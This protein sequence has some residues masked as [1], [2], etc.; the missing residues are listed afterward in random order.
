MEGDTAFDR[1]I[2]GD[3]LERWRHRRRLPSALRL[4]RATSVSRLSA[5][6]IQGLER[7][8]D[9]GWV[10]GVPQRGGETANRP[11]VELV[12]EDIGLTDLPWEIL[13]RDLGF[14]ALRT[15]AV[16]PRVA[17]V[18]LTVPLRMLAVDAPVDA[19][20]VGMGFAALSCGAA[21]VEQFVWDGRWPTVD[22]LH[23]AGFGDDDLLDFAH[24][25]LARTAGWIE[26]I[27]HLHHV[28][29]LVL[30]CPRPQVAN[31]RRLVSELADRGGPAMAVVEVG[32][33]VLPQL[34][35]ALVAPEGF[36]G[37]YGRLVGRGTLI[38][39]QARLELL[40]VNEVVR[41]I[42]HMAEHPRHK[43]DAQLL[44]LHG[45]SLVWRMFEAPDLSYVL[46]RDID[47]FR[48]AMSA[49]PL[50]LMK[51]F[52]GEKV[53]YLVPT[54]AREGQ[55]GVEQISEAGEPLVLD[56][57]IQLQV[58]V[59]PSELRVDVLDAVALVDEIFS[60]DHED[61]GTWVELGVTGIDTDIQG[62]AVQQLWVPR[63]GPSQTV[64]FTVIPRAG[65][66]YVRLAIYVEQ[67]VA[68]TILISMLAR[69]PSM[70]QGTDGR[71][72]MSDQLRRDGRTLPETLPR[73]LARV[74]Y[75]LL[76][77][78]SGLGAIP[79]RAASVVVNHLAGTDVVT[80]KYA[81]GQVDVRT[82]GMAAAGADVRRALE[83]ISTITAAEGARP[84][85]Y[86]FESDE[87][88]DPAL[89][90]EYL[91]PLAA[92]GRGLFDSMIPYDARE[93]VSAVVQREGLPVHVANL[94]MEKA[95]PWAAVYDRPI[96]QHE[97]RYLCTAALPD[98]EGVMPGVA[99]GE[100]PA[101]LLSANGS[102]GELL[103]SEVICPQ[104]FW[105]FRQNV[106]M[107]V[108]RS[109]PGKH[110]ADAARATAKQS[111]T[112]VGLA[113][114]RGLTV[115]G[116]HHDELVKLLGAADPRAQKSW[117][118]EN[119]RSL[120][121]SLNNDPVDLIYF[122]SHAN[123]A[124]GTEGQAGS[125]QVW[126]PN[127][128]GVLTALTRADFEGKSWP[129]RPLV[130]LNGCRTAASDPSAISAL[131]Q[132]LTADR[133]AGGAIGT[134]IA[135]W[136]QLASCVGQLLV[137]RFLASDAAGDALLFARRRL[138]GRHNPLGLAYSLYATTEFYALAQAE[139]V[140][141]AAA[142]AAAA[143]S[144]RLQGPALSL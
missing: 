128:K 124:D 87:P 1:E 72:A 80:V 20:I 37:F 43:F 74:E 69:G 32:D 115:G 11:L 133:G 104:G 111:P 49:L 5:L 3:V 52:H 110:A 79:A 139:A 138:L 47:R 8:Q 10:S 67:N 103:A 81:G 101:C 39:G 86:R 34:L 44:E 127:E 15:S 70:A 33:T 19:A 100:A 66:S 25:Q 71:E 137:E 108:Q 38:G 106:E 21:N 31:A 61:G 144:Q 4:G 62:N 140:R 94:V 121:H 98:R 51:L 46:T 89:L 30:E 78:M 90:L 55:S 141:P 60:W 105:G 93:A 64:T 132:E 99:C 13:V 114:Y 95:V 118:V 119:V 56:A 18:P 16:P 83:R 2:D 27:V 116:H 88:G 29:L 112:R 134:E 120:L 22:V 45:A 125:G 54:L 9:R 135:V 17:Q 26:R 126:Y 36:G 14:L 12:I 142:L 57:P 28:R 102:Q 35:M 97:A 65:I 85:R 73:W 59:R 107:P 96:S 42:N 122:M 7:L 143:P 6:A 68:Q 48:S 76:S 23:I 131:M 136:E 40:D 113:V 109:E 63:T 129:D 24:P 91:T 84:D 41:C 77:D 117:D 50:R 92:A 75:A 58:R 123:A 53:R 130:I 82:S